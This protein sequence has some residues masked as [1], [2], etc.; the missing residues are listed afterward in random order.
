MSSL[1]IESP[2]NNTSSSSNS[3]NNTNTREKLRMMTGI[4]TLTPSNPSNDIPASNATSNATSND[5]SYDNSAYT[6][7]INKFITFNMNNVN[8]SWY[9]HH[10]HHP[11]N[12]YHHYHLLIHYHHY[13]LLHNYHHHHRY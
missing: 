8:T 6:N 2:M 5:N 3:I 7:I 11:H 4:K 12:L 13:P 10:C 1:T 9:N